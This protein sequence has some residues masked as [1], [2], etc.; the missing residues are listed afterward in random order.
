[1]D[2]T[3][4]TSFAEYRESEKDA[5]AFGLSCSFYAFFKRFFDIVV[6]AVSLIV[7]AIPF[8]LISLAIAFD[9]RGRVIFKQRRVGRGGKEFF[10]YKFRTMSVDAPSMVATGDLTCAHS[11]ITRVGRFLRK[12]SLDELPQLINV[13]KGD[14]S[15]VGPRPLIINESEIHQ[16]RTDAG[17]YSVRPGV[18]GWAQ[19][20]GRDNVSVDEKVRLDKYYVNNKSVV[21]DLHIILKTVWVVIIKKGY[22][23]G[24]QKYN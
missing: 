21:F 7:L 5:S 10:I 11:Y 12:T 3:G 8:V 19:V 18:T 24:K 15:V 20:N 17:I 4:Y 16:R 6:S 9:S 14:M 22:A 2:N 13:L 1:M 23:E